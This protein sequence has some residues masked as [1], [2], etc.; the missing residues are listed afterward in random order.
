M[1]TLLFGTIGCVGGPIGA[2]AL[3]SLGA[4]I[5]AAGQ[6]SSSSNHSYVRTAPPAST[7]KSDWADEVDPDFQ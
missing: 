1:F 5:D 6:T 7:P 4:C 2:L 3:G